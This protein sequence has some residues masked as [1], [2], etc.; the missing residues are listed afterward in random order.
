LSTTPARPLHISVIQSLKDIAPAQ[1]DAC[2]NPIKTNSINTITTNPDSFSQ[3][4]DSN[5][6]QPDSC[7]E[8]SPYN[9]FISHGF[10]ASLEHSGSVGPGT[11]WQPVHILLKD[12]TGTLQAAAPL[13]LKSHSMG[14]YV[15]DQG[16]AQ[17][18]ERAGG[19]YYPKLQMSAPFTPATGPRL[20]LRD[21]AL[22][23]ALI[24]AVQSLRATLKASSV[25][26]TFLPKSQWDSL[27][28]AGFLQRTDQQFHFSM[29]PMPALRAFWRHCP[30]ASAR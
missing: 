27:G 29:R 1:W 18:Y 6:Q 10:L 17:A 3:I 24:S 26:A 2:A 9:P 19:V 12:E 8:P 5:Y 21:P 16:W 11:G 20:L 14:E 4:P 13:Y 15:F 25:H 30:R 23:P 22:V 7:S 28:E